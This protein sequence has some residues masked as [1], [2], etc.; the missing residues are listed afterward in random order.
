MWQAALVDHRD[1]P[2]ACAEF[3]RGGKTETTAA[4]DEDGR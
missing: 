4:E 3:E 2:T 1:L